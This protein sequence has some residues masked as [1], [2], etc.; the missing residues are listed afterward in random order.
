MS[1]KAMAENSAAAENILAAPSGDVM[2]L[3]YGLCP[4]M[5]FR[6]GRLEAGAKA[7]YGYLASFAGAGMTAFPSQ[8]LMLKE[9]KMSRP[10]YTKHLKQLQALGYVRVERRRNKRNEYMSNIYEL[11]RE[12]EIDEER[13]EAYRQLRERSLS[14]SR[15]AQAGKA[16]K[17]AEAVEETLA[18]LFEAGV[19]SMEAL[20]GIVENCKSVENSPLSKNFTMEEKASSEPVSK[21]FTVEGPPSN[22]FTEPL[23]NSFTVVNTVISNKGK[24]TGITNP[25][26]L[27][28][29]QVVTGAASD[30]QDGGQDREKETEASG[31]SAL[32]TASM[33]PVSALRAKAV[34]KAYERRVAEGYTP[35]DIAQAYEAYRDAYVSEH[36]NLK[37]AKQLDRWLLEGDGLVTYAAMIEVGPICKRS[38]AAKASAATPVNDEE[39]RALSRADNEALGD[40]LER[41]DPIFCEMRARYENARRRCTETHDSDDWEAWKAIGEQLDAYLAANIKPARAEFLRL[42]RKRNAAKG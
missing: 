23:S 38:A 4:Q 34:E 7:I 28:D 2:S 31:L 13:M 12:P 1:S 10:T 41:A 30:W 39:R 20:A 40:A 3:G 35:E 33:K 22:S 42:L 26:T 27:R 14:A 16:A 8:D 17:S 36:S 29:S 18:A 37:Q 19:L 11:V 6:D 5:V 9:L 25:P 15:A 21:N 32:C 24:V